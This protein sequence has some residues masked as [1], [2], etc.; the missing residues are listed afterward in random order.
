[1]AEALPLT[2][3]LGVPVDLWDAFWVLT[4]DSGQAVR[5]AFLVLYGLEIGT[6]VE[7]ELEIEVVRPTSGWLPFWVT[8]SLFILTPDAA[9]LSGCEQSRFGDP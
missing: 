8:A 6:I 7:D 2:L 4:V 5:D 9:C 3:Y 1:M